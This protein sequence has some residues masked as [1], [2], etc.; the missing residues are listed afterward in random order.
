[1]LSYLMIQCSVE[2]H[3]TFSAINR[4]TKMT[5]EN[6]PNFLL[7]LHFSSIH[8]HIINIKRHIQSPTVVCSAPSE[9][10][11]REEEGTASDGVSRWPYWPDS[12]EHASRF[13]RQHC[14]HCFF[15]LTLLF[16]SFSL[17]KGGKHRAIFKTGFSQCRYH[18]VET[19]GSPKYSPS[20][21]H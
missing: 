7:V 20:G 10:K 19:Q 1:M 14:P 4:S 16:I 8:S 9:N 18:A 15:P 5:T 6:I 12:E 3:V 11:A 17:S 13:C 21:M 2:V